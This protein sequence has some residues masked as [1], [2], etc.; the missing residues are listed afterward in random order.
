MMNVAAMTLLLN[1]SRGSFGVSLGDGW[2]EPEQA[3]ERYDIPEA[4]GVPA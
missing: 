4:R 1:N 2:G 3:P